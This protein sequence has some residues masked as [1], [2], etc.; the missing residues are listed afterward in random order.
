MSDETKVFDGTSQE[1]VAEEIE[2]PSDS[3]FGYIVAMGKDG[4]LH[5]QTFGGPEGL[6]KTWLLS[7]LHQAVSV[8][9]QSNLEKQINTSN[10]A[11]LGSML[12]TTRQLVSVMKAIA[13][14]RQTPPEPTNKE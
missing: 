6:K 9:I 11:T 12:E 1:T 2:I 3:E 13:S 4:S 7:G 14:P 10:A 5:F 8:V